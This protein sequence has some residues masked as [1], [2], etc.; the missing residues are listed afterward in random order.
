M[1]Q[2]VVGELTKAKHNEERALQEK[3]GAVH[4]SP[5]SYAQDIFIRKQIADI[6]DELKES[7]LKGERG[8][9]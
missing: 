7:V 8:G 5:S 3:T 9:E 6:L 1:S 2:A 4:E